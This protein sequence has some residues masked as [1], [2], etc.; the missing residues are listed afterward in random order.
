MFNLD[1]NYSD[2]MP[3][4]Q[5]EAL[6]KNGEFRTTRAGTEN[7]D[8]TLIIRN[9][10]EQPCQGRHMHYNIWKKKDPNKLDKA[11]ENYNFM[12]INTL[13]KA[14]ELPDKKQY[15]SLQ[16]W[17]NDLSQKPLL[18]LVRHEEYNGQTN[19]RVRQVGLSEHK[20]VKH[21]YYKEDIP[22]KTDDFV[23]LDAN[24]DDLPF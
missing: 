6:I 21:V 3:E 12:S 17:L 4:G 23:Y 19:A 5:Y 10:I 20:E 18:I 8:I 7:I 2:L 15:K 24:D 1:H 16:E 14:I 9:D 11:C 22:E 13:S